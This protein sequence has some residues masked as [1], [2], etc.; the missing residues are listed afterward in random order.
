[1]IMG[2]LTAASTRPWVSKAENVGV[3][4]A[5]YRGIHPSH[6]ACSRDDRDR[7]KRVLCSFFVS[8]GKAE[9]VQV[10]ECDDADHGVCREPFGIA[11]KE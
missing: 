8:D 5:H 9:V 1:M 4:W 7:N 10:Y 3:E 6:V 11:E 2:A